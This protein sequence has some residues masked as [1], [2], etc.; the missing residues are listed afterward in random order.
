MNFERIR[1]LR[2]EKE[3]TQAKMAE[4]LDTK[5]S[6][7]SLWEIGKNIIPL[8]KLII[9]CDMF[10][11]SIDYITKLSNNKKKITNKK[12]IDSKLIGKRLKITRKDLK[13]TQEKLADVLGTTH[14]A[15]SAYENGITLIPT[16]FLYE[17]SKRYNISMDYLTCRNNE[18]NIS[19]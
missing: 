19:K 3:L 5:R 11:Q 8:K 16:I 9:L 7:Y 14:S 4:L 10:N 12:S 15:I 2:E 18:K 1:Y 6:A 13:L 17:F